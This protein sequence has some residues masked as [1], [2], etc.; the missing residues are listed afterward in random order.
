MGKRALLPLEAFLHNDAGVRKGLSFMRD[1]LVRN[2]NFHFLGTTKQDI[3]SFA[4]PLLVSE[5]LYQR[6]LEWTQKI[7]DTL[8]EVG[9]SLRSSLLEAR[10]TLLFDS[11]L[12]EA[13]FRMD[14][15]FPKMLPIFR[16]DFALNSSNS[17]QLLEVN[18]G[19]PGGE[20]DP[21]LVAEAFSESPLG[22]DL[23]DRLGGD[24]VPEDNRLLFKD[25]RE[26]SLTKL[27]NCYESFRK[28][29]A[30]LP[31]SPTIALVTSS[32]QA[33]FMIPE[34]RGIAEHYQSRGYRTV[35]GD[36]SALEKHGDQ[37][38]LEGEAIHL[39]F[40]KFSTRSFR[41]RMEDRLRFGNEICKRMWRIWEALAQGQI[42]LVN[43][44]GSTVLQDKGIIALM[45][46]RFP[47]LKAAIPETHILHA[48]LPS[49]DPALWKEIR[50]GTPY[51]LKRRKSF[52]GKH[53]ILNPEAV[54]Q[55]A[56][57]LLRMSPN[58]WVA[59]RRVPIAKFPFAV[60]ERGQVKVGRFRFNVS[61]F[62]DSCFVRLG[63][64][65]HYQP[66]SAHSGCATTFALVLR[67][68]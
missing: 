19:C 18:C 43:P 4:T 7:A 32:A 10:E 11:P 60:W 57:R 61:P 12:E 8:D 1:V 27:V 26:E 55:R 30:N 64:G 59:Q 20:L 28:T 41:L 53:V 68:G 62:G 17:P 66:L 14:P 21:A 35:V 65:D 54:R 52:G 49:E 2:G 44:L 40:R 58:Q 33:H 6:L 37:V 3:Y 16:I 47:Q 22:N 29:H 5:N 67:G 25:P 46:Q 15:G 56:P 24:V 36:I 42:C 13:F 23:L 38:F 50:N 63:T 31:E 45:R 34:C 51:I 9:L 48:A 39:V